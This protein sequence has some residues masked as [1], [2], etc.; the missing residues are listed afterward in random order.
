MSEVIDTYWSFRSPYSYLATPDLLKLREDYDVEVK[1]RVVLPLAVRNKASVFDA[2]NRKPS[3]YIVRDSKRRS[4][5][6]GMDLVFPPSPDPVV[7]DYE[8]FEVAEEQPLLLRLCRLGVEAERRGRGLE[9]AA[10]VS[11]LIMGG[12][13]GWD[14]GDHLHRAVAS[15]G[16]DLDE[17]D[18]AIAGGDQLEEIEKNH[19]GL[20]AAGH[21]G[22]PTMVVRGE[23]FFG[24]DRIETLRWRLDQYGLRRA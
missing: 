5:F 18:S 20:E 10:A 21:W 23:P 9:L 4:E 17:L 1:L 7:Q 13:R 24:Q 12:T 2:S 3:L 22:V 6:L 16:L 8:T 11:R 15:A 14:E 19:E